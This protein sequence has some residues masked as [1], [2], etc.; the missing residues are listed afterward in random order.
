MVKQTLTSTEMTDLI[1]RT[2]ERWGIHPILINSGECA[3]FADT[4]CSKVE[5]AV[6]LWGNSVPQ[7]FSNKHQPWGHCFISWNGKFYDAEEPD[8]VS[9]PALLPFFL[10]QVTEHLGADLLNA[11]A[12]ER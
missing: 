12:N 7:Y 8:G 3:D 5:G 10:R 4:I 11:L 1:I 2:A 6:A 9:S